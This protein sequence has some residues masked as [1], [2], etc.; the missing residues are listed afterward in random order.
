MKALWFIETSVTAYH[1]TG[2]NVWEDVILIFNLILNL[3]LPASFV[4]VLQI[5]RFPEGFL[6]INAWGR[7]TVISLGTKHVRDL[8]FCQ[9]CKKCSVEK[10]RKLL[11]WIKAL[12]RV[13]GL[14]WLSCVGVQLCESL[15]KWKRYW[16][17]KR[18][19]I[20][21]ARHSEFVTLPRYSQDQTCR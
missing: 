9:A 16:L 8:W 3:M 5:W 7:V 14:Y 11:R 17:D 10:V 6:C 2:R 15:V 18:S 12:C 19:D 1:L 20:I 13:H 21:D 4:L